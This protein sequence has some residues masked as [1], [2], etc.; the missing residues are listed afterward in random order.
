M[1]ALSRIW[2]RSRAGS[3]VR[4]WIHFRVLLSDY[5]TCVKSRPT[6]SA[7]PI[8]V[9]INSDDFLLQDLFARFFECCK[10]FKIIFVFLFSVVH[11]CCCC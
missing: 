5:C 3:S 10:M 1:C 2:A 4:K 6:L 7:Q 9:I 8:P 11:R